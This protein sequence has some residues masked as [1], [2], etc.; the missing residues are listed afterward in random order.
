[1]PSQKNKAAVKVIDEK[2]KESKNIIFIDHSGLSVD[3]QNDIRLKLREV[4]SEFTVQK[5]TL[6][7]LVLKNRTKD[8]PEELFEA[9]N[10]PTSVVYGYE[11]AVATT[12]IVVDFAKEHEEDFQLKVGV[13]AGTDDAPHTFLTIESMKNLATLPGKDELRAKLVGQL[14]APV[15]GFYNVLSGNLRGLVT[16]LGAIKDQKAD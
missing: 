2:L 15:Q 1:M 5:N 11:D 16:V 13:L 6:L 7:K 4:G 3:D 10:G 12:K 14:N 8:L 9:L